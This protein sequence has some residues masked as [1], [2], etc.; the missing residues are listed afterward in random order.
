MQ[1][2]RPPVLE[3][4]LHPL[5]FRAASSPN[6]LACLSQ[7]LGPFSK[8]DEISVGQE[9]SGIVAL[10]RFTDFATLELARSV[11]DGGHL[12]QYARISVRVRTPGEEEGFDYEPPPEFLPQPGLSP[13]RDQQVDP[14]QQ[15]NH[16]Y[17]PK[18][19]ETVGAVPLNAPHTRL[20]SAHEPLEH[21]PQNA[22]YP[23]SLKTASPRNGVRQA[24]NAWTFGLNLVAV[25][26]LP[27]QDGARELP[28]SNEFNISPSVWS[29]RT[30]NSNF[31]FSGMSPVQ[32]LL[33]ALDA[34]ATFRNLKE[35]ANFFGLFGRVSRV[36][37]DMNNKVVLAEFESGAHLTEALQNPEMHEA[38]RLMTLVLQRPDF[39]SLDVAASYTTPPD[40][41]HILSVRGIQNRELDPRRTR[42]T[43]VL[44]IWCPD[45]RS[46]E[47][48]QFGSTL[49]GEVYRA[50]RPTEFRATRLPGCEGPVFEAA[51]SS[52]LDSMTVYLKMNGA[53][54]KGYQVF[55]RFV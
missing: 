29:D 43:S 6:Y 22:S 27:Q 2:V 11:L 46:S 13:S 4:R 21:K 31:S 36:A 45:S 1:P 51:F 23:H 44:V 9:R 32:R 8:L 25:E 10:V 48:P 49:K 18:L 28:P 14:Q 52:K 53:R 54:V 24:T 42:L 17:P 41:F 12:N 5:D 3:V 26:G 20:Q 40:K 38:M 16:R 33:A 7:L 34:R 39:G 47:C 50:C 37:L 19:P 15:I 55:A 30:S 35:V